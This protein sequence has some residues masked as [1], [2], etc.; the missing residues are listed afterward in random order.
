M[1]DETADSPTTAEPP[2]GWTLWNDEPSGRRILAYR[3]DVFN[4]SD[5][6]AECMPTIFVWNGSRAN[7]PGASRIRTETW[8]AILRLEPDVEC[9]IE[10]YDSREAAVDGANELARR[11]A[12]GEIAYRECYQV[13]PEAYLDRL[14][15][16]TG[17]DE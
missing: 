8:R 2:G 11:F 10:E 5:F 13:P 12:D 16:L 4:E 1:T 6:P 15:E 14:D 17:R 3:P 9:V 7:R